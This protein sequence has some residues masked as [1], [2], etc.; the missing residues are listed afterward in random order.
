MVCRSTR[1]PPPR[2]ELLRGLPD[3][4]PTREVP[5]LGQPAQ[6]LAIGRTLEMLGDPR[7]SRGERE[8]L[9]AAEDVLERVEE[10]EQEAAVE[11]HGARHVAEQHQ[12]HL[13]P[14]P[15]P[16]PQLDDLALHHVGPHAPP[17][18]DDP[19]P[20]GRPPATADAP[21]RQPL[22]D[23][24]REPG[25]LVEILGRKR[26]EVLIHQDL[27]VAD[28]RH[29]ERLA[30]VVAFLL[31]ALERHRD[32]LLLGLRPGVC[33]RAPPRMAASARARQAVEPLPL[34]GLEASRTRRS[35]GR[36][37][38]S[39]RRR[40]TRAGAQRQVHL[41]AVQQVDDLERPHRV[42]QL[43]HRPRQPRPRAASGR[44]GASRS[45][46]RGG[47]AIADARSPRPARS[48]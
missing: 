24:D 9:D 5:H 29:L 18:V 8:G 2:V 28:S 44:S 22:G 1:L 21:A 7:E 45:G 47:A 13:A 43:R 36:T 3:P 32:L 35:S 11:V 27:A 14:P 37:R 33:R 31:P 12:A 17:Q 26:R 4:R 23:Q 48:A 41:L 6:G 25:D 34:L 20:P 42:H 40:A 30:V 39:P 15:L 38:G 10:L 19:A 46:G 16:S